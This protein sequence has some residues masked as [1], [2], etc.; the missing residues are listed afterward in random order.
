MTA[1]QS[2]AAT[3]HTNHDLLVQVEGNS[4]KNLGDPPRLLDFE[5]VNMNSNNI[6]GPPPAGPPPQNHN[7]PPGPNLHMPAPDLRTMEE[8]CQPTMNGRGGPIAPGALPSDTIPN[9]GGVIK[10]ITTQSGIVLDGPSVPPPPLFSSSK[11]VERDPEMIMDHV[12]IESTIRVPHPVVHL[13]KALA[14]MPKYHKMLKALLSDKEKLL[15]LANTSLTENYSVVLLKKLP[16]KLR[17][18]RRFLI[19]CDFHG[20]E[21]YMA[22]ADLATMSIAYL[23]GIAE[24]V[25][26]QVG[27]FT[28]LANF[29]VIDYEV[30]SCVLLILERPFLMMARALVDDRFPKVLKIKKS[31][32]PS[33]SSTTPLFDSLPSLT[34]F[35]T[36]DSLLEEFA[37]ELVLLDSFPTRNEDDNFDSEADLRKIVYLLN[38]DPSTDSDTAII[39]PFS[40]ANFV[41]SNDL[42]S[43]LLDSDSTLPEESSESSDIATLSS[44]PF[45][46]KDKR[47]LLVKS[48]VHIEVLS[49]LWENRKPVRTVRSRCLGGPEFDSAMAPFW[50]CPRQLPLRS[51]CHVAT[52]TQPNPTQTRPDPARPLFRPPLIGG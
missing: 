42:L 5:E 6:Q 18:P 27:K 17:D 7:G 29:V 3:W 28:F 35:E 30:N 12:P 13:K 45:E 50:G 51:H 2:E 26:V 48:K 19:P 11:E 8:L 43:Q 39:D 33:S 9:P 49:V 52:L 24:D 40:S 41:E 22:L 46:N 44:S 16:E 31:N 14:L 36:S 1:G 23:A 32:H 47:F 10:A 34:P 15:R 25:C 21:S 38:Q 20:L 37:D 4:R